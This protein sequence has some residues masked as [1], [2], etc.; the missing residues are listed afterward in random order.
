MTH[1]RQDKSLLNELK[2]R[3]KHV[4]QASYGFVRHR[5]L[6]HKRIQ[7]DRQLSESWT[8]EQSCQLLLKTYPQ[9][10]LSSVWRSPVVLSSNAVEGVLTGGGGE[11]GFGDWGTA[12]MAA[13][14]R[15]TTK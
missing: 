8:Q 1:K 14:D 2:D 11:A 6:N 3:I 7:H 12:L 5:P 9:P 13:G 10:H 15:G 4:Y